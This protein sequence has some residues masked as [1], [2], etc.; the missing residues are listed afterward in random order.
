MIASAGGAG[1]LQ[2]HFLLKIDQHSGNLKSFRCQKVPEVGRLHDH[3]TDGQLSEL[4]RVK[5]TSGY[6]AKAIR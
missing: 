4:T 6:A 3:T 2:G 5:I 1:L